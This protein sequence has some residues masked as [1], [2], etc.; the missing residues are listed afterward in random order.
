[1]IKTYIINPGEKP[2]EEQLKEVEAAKNKPITFDKDSEE[3]SPA[4]IKAFRSVAAHRNR[5][6]DV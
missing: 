4:M 3:M 1:M 6:K 2:T 5:R